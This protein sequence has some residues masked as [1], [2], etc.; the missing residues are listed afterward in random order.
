MKTI[1]IAACA[2]FLAGGSARAEI[3]ADSIK[4][5]VLTD[6]SGVY[7]A[8][9][10]PGS[11]VAAQLAADDFGGA[12]NGKPIVILQ[13]DNQNKVDVGLTIARQWYDRDGVLAIA[14]LIPS[15]VALGVEDLVRQNHRIALISG[16]AA[17]SIFQEN[18]A[19]TAFDWVQDT[20]SI[21]NGTV[22]GVW[23]RTKAPWFFISADLVPAAQLEQQARVKL[24][25]LGG[26][27]AG[28]V[29]APF[30]TTDF[31]A[32]LLEAQAAGGGV[33]A[34][35]TLGGSIATVKQ[36]VEFGLTKAMTL[37]LTTT[38][39]Q[40]VIAIGLPV[41]KGQLLVTSFYE[42]VSPEARIWTDR[43]MARTHRLPTETQAGVY[44]SVRHMLQAV[45]DTN[46]DDGETVAAQM[47]KT[48]VIDAYTRHGNIRPDGRLSHELYL[49]QVKAPDE[50]KDPQT[51]IWRRVATIA[52]EHAF[53]PMS[54]TR[55]PLAKP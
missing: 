17:E 33:L 50:S 25:E 3:R 10:G 21:A 6:M 7:A 22:D 24:A 9:G 23:Q 29:K 4:V 42:D 20:Y 45:K 52:P 18:C 41:A 54:A 55:C 34:V 1:A 47:R 49:M 15:P 19:S 13:A 39:S 28:S 48:P 31:S 40:D 8:N 53:P 2:A 44:S 12:I 36:A 5:G 35:N 32:Y 14:D 27:I 30:T 46:S 38:K 37:V 11:V 16:A 26:K 51:D 43:F